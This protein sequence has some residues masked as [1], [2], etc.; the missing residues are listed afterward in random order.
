VI[1]LADF[2]VCKTDRFKIIKIYAPE[3]FL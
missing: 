3:F 1:L 2:Q